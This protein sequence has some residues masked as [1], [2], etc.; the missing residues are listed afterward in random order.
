MTAPPTTD[1]YFAEILRLTD[2]VATTA[3]FSRGDPEFTVDAAYRVVR[4]VLAGREAGGWRRVGRKIGFS[5]YTILAQYGVTEPMF[6]Y[7]YDRTV[8]EAM[9]GSGGQRAAL[10][11][12]PLAQPRIEPEIAFKLNSRPQPG[13]GPVALLRHIEWMA[14]GFEIVQCHFPDWKFAAPDAVADGGLHGRYIIGP[15]LEVAPVDP[16]ALATQLAGFTITLVKDGAV[17]ASGGGVNVLGS[18]LDALEFLVRTLSHLPDH[19]ALEAGE[20]ITTG[21]LTAALPIAPGETWSTA[22]SGLPL[23]GFE[24]RFA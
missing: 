14:H 16:E 15:R 4:S 11:L 10:A 19:P 9:T 24:V 5:N 1:R 21:T 18:P 8:S 22:I 3:P 13:E 2:A 17:A 7:M 20:V 12:A 23:P 6:G